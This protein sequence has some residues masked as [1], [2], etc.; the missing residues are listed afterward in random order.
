MGAIQH[1][2]VF[3]IASLANVFNF[4]MLSEQRKKKLK[5]KNS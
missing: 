4:K 1:L 3:M 5:F 2:A